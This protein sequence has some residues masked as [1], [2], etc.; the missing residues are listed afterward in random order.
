M[1]EERAVA[2]ASS[3]SCSP[4]AATAFLVLRAVFAGCAA[5]DSAPCAAVL[6]AC[7][8]QSALVSTPQDQISN[9]SYVSPWQLPP[10]LKEDEQWVHRLGWVHDNLRADVS[11]GES[12]LLLEGAA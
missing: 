1:R 5:P 11:R 6:G 8:A 9:T 12:P 7:R 10:V 4:S 3:P 2:P